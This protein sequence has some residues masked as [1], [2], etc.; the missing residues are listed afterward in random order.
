MKECAPRLLSQFGG[1]GGKADG[2]ESAA[3]SPGFQEACR[4]EGFESR[5]EDLGLRD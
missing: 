1:G 5:V 2:F 4:V 3:L